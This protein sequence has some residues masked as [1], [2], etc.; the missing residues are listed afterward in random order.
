[1]EASNINQNWSFQS[2][3]SLEGLRAGHV[4]SLKLPVLKPGGRPLL[5]DEWTQASETKDALSLFPLFF[6]YM[7]IEYGEPS[8]DT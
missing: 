6:K 3:P 2:P 8:F 1:M 5:T 4:L 7:Y